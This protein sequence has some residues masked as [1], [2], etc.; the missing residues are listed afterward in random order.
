MVRAVTRSTHLRSPSPDEVRALLAEAKW[1]QARAAE[2]CGVTK[3]AMENYVSARRRMQ[4]AHWH[5][6]EIYARESVRAALPVAV[7]P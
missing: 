6:L 5:V 2:I 3:A 1:T 7:L 4:G